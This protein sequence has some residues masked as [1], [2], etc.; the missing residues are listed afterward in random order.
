MAGRETCQT[1]PRARFSP[2]GPQKGLFST[3]RPVRI[4]T[5]ARP[6]RGAADESMVSSSEQ[7]PKQAGFIAGGPVL[8]RVSYAQ[9][10]RVGTW[11][12]NC[13]IPSR[14]R[15]PSPVSHQRQPDPGTTEGVRR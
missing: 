1:N 7:H 4:T 14:G 3:A 9:Q 6:R 2:T 10:A 12:R 5:T 15:L 13:S 11:T 8:S